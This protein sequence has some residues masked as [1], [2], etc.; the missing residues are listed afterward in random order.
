MSF[1]LLRLGASV[2]LWASNSLRLFC[3]LQVLESGDEKEM[4]TQNCKATQFYF[5]FRGHPEHGSTL[6]GLGVKVFPP[7]GQ[8]PRDGKGTERWLPRSNPV[9]G[10]HEKE[11][12]AEACNGSDWGEGAE[13]GHRIEERGIRRAGSVPSIRP[14]RFGY[15]KQDPTVIRQGAGP[16]GKAGVHGWSRL[17]A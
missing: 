6:Q 12:Q 10:L 5:G 1:G 11:G 14:L 8:R 3:K 7:Q 13:R 17:G 4:E 2:P 9:S 15:E 16:A